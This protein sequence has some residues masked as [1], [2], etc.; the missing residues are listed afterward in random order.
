[1]LILK[2]YRPDLID[3][4]EIKKASPS[5]RMEIVFR[6]AEKELGIPKLLDVEGK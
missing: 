5:Q 1:M 4:A 3:F 2:N 6:V